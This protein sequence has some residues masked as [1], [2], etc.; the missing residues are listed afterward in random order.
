MGGMRMAMF[1]SAADRAG[2]CLIQEAGYQ[3]SKEGT[4]VYLTAGP[5]WKISSV[6]GSR[7]VERGIVAAIAH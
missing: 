3:P 2:G 4:V 6:S 1:P 5:S 7:S